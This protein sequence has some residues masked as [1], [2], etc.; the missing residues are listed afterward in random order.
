MQGRVRMKPPP[1]GFIYR[2]AWRSSAAD[3]LFSRASPANAGIK[4]AAPWIIS[5]IIPSV[6]PESISISTES[7]AAAVK[8]FTS[9]FILKC[10]PFG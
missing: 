5:E 10:T 9:L 1:S 4:N 6:E 8:I 7:S 3:I 2:L